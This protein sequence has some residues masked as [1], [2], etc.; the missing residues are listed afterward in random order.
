M[1]KAARKE[2]GFLLVN[3]ETPF[4][5]KEAFETLR[6]N[7]IYTTSTQEAGNIF[8]VTSAEED[9]GKSTIL[10]NLAMSFATADKKVLLI[11]ADMRC[12]TQH[13]FFG[14][15]ESQA[16]LSEFLSDMIADEK[17]IIIASNVKN[18]DMV[19][20]GHIPPN[21]SELL[22]SRKFAKLIAYAKEKYDYVFIDLPPVGVVS[23]AISLVK[24]VSGYILVVR[25]NASKNVGV[26]DAIEKLDSIGGNIVGV[27]FND[28]T[29]KFGM[30]GTRYGRSKYG[31]YSKYSKYNKYVASDKKAHSD[32]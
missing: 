12:P 7:V 19:H 18:L 6:T 32:K 29:Y 24:L 21:P 8:V 25:A 11:D 22:L 5:I 2:N 23:D 1:K 31:K 10:A 26:R 15:G 14:F 9:A 13:G 4:A 27:V 3:E 30:Y 16:G 20:A 28:I 17:D